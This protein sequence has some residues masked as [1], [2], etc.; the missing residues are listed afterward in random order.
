MR[1]AIVHGRYRQ[2]GGE[3]NVVE[4]E[5]ELLQSRGVEVATFIRD[6]NSFPG[7]GS[8]RVA[9][10]AVWSRQIASEFGRFLESER[11][12][13]IHV[14]N[15][16]P[17][18]SPAVFHVANHRDIPAVLTLHNYRLFCPA[19]TLFRNGSP[20][21]ACISRSWAWPAVF[22][23]CYRES[24]AASAAVAAVNSIHRA[25]GTWTRSISAYV[26]LTEFAR[27]VCQRGGLPSDRLHIRPNYVEAPSRH[28]NAVGDTRA[29]AV[30]VGRISEEKG[31]RIL[32][33]E[34]QKVGS[35]LDVYGDGPLLEDLKESTSAMIRFH[36]FVERNRAIEALRKSAFLVV[37][38][39]WY[40]AFPLVVLEA[41]SL[42]IPVLASNVG[43]LSEVVQHE[44]TGLHFDP[45]QPDSLSSAA[46][47]LLQDKQ[48]RNRCAANARTTYLARYTP[49]IAYERLIEIYESARVAWRQTKPGI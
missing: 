20:C 37:P 32:T 43:S 40:E 8:A 5:I 12:D 9:V 39:I 25:L 10:E 6:N 24:R 4:Q 1:V 46:I 28:A 2:P 42:G 35:P 29:R 13:V 31:V 36:G 48:L 47:R 44:V 11:P 34:W 45:H 14:H 17:F 27:D 23:G 30:F 33:R 22:H 15:T 26:V 16:F 19:A 7:E 3:D 21:E 18:L 38:S 41:F 49:D